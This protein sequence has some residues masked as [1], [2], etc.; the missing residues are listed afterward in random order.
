[1]RRVKKNPISLRA[2]ILG[3]FFSLWLL[4]IGGKVV[5]V[6]VF[7]GDRLSKKAS[8][9]YE[10][11]VR[12]EGKRG[13]I[14]DRNRR[15]MAVSSDVTSIAA[16]PAQLPD[17]DE[18]SAMLAKAL[19][20][21]QMERNALVNRLT[22]DKSFVW[23]QR[24]VTP[25]ERAAVSV[26]GI[27]GIDF[28]SERK[29]N[30]PNTTLAAQVLGFTGTDGYG[31]GGIESRY[32]EEL[33]GN[34]KRLTVLR[35]A[36]GRGFFSEEQNTVETDGNGLVLSI[37]ATIQFIAEQALKEAV[38]SFS[39]ESAMAVVMDPETGAVLAM[40]H[41]PFFN[42]NVFL[43]FEQ[44]KWRNRAVMDSFEPGSTMKV[45]TAAAA[46]E[47]G[48]VTPASIFFC[49]N[50]SYRV[51]GHTINDTH[52]NGWL[53]LQQIV[54][55]S[56]NIGAVKVLERIG[57]EALYA[58]FRDFGFGSKTGIDCPG[59]TAGRLRPY[60]QWWGVDASTIS[61]GQGVSVSAV[62]LAAAVSVFANDGI[63]MKPYVVQA[64]VDAEGN[65]VKR[66]EP[67]AV[68]RVVSTDTARTVTRIMETVTTEGGTGEGVALE[69][70]SVAGKTGT[71]QKAGENGTYEKGLYVS[72]FVGFV[73]AD[74]PQATIVVIVDKPEEAYYGGT[75]AG[76]AFRKIAEGLLQYLNVPPTGLPTNSPL[77]TIEQLTVS[78]GH[79]MQG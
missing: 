71:A 25:K 63:L 20:M 32:N 44:W 76:P 34:S 61:F 24:K 2:T 29:R 62:Q 33:S 37:D 4:V 35:D 56:S 1:M 36:L 54:K 16:Y 77:E 41:Y 57:H 73:P 28:C 75:V 12:S 78:R 10:R 70:Y 50:G 49:E 8:D 67:Q 69:G 51:S 46:I 64:V 74:D 66:F 53:S 30:Y 40:A 48:G 59:E 39:A 9:Q 17:L 6:Q 31:L 58:T 19:Q 42:P 43:E 38:T 18:A 22:L 3:V 14:F 13:V 47:K 68:R 65:D 5:H 11:S 60:R 27:K 26:L 7:Q 79:G 21:E 55:Y 15:E 52:E 45:F 23:V 72:S